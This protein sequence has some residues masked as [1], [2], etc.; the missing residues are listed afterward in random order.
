MLN[1]SPNMIKLSI[2]KFSLISVFTFASI[3]I[4]SLGACV[5]LEFDTPPA[6]GFDPNLPV[7]TTIAELKAMHTL[8]SYEEITDDIIIYGIVISNADA[9]NF[10]KQ[11]VIQ[12]STGG[13]ELR[14]EMSDLN[15]FYPVGRKVY[16]KAK[17]LWLGD[18]NGLIQLGAGHDAVEDDLIRIAE[19]LVDKV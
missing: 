18:Y 7:N 3:L 8:G 4:M 17:G 12:D 9:G 19:S 2:N 6:G 1:A 15:N 10:F 5:D 13:I 14:I 16:V 11:L